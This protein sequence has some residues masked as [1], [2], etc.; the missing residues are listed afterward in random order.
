MICQTDIQ[1]LAPHR[2]DLLQR[3]AIGGTVRLSMLRTVDEHAAELLDAEVGP[4]KN[5]TPR[6]TQP[7]SKAKL[8]V[9][10][11]GCSRMVDADLDNLRVAM[12]RSERDRDDDTALRIATALYGT[13]TALI[14]G[15]ATNLRPLERGAAT[16]TQALAP[17]R[18]RFHYM[19]GERRQ[20][21]TSGLAVGARSVPTTPP[22]HTHR[23]EP[24]RTRATSQAA[25]QHLVQRVD[26]QNS[27]WT[28]TSSSP[29]TS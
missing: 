11:K 1:Q 16:S 2:F 20:R 13:T 18:C 28:R 23:V 10:V 19:L 26:R 21:R 29:R 7:S 24:C 4:R 15:R 17:R 9:R 3:T 6:I 25:M 14:F 27:D 5:G 22:R 8:T 12:D